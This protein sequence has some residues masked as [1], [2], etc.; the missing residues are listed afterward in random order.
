MTSRFLA[1]PIIRKLFRQMFRDRMR[2]NKKICLFL[3][4]TLGPSIKKIDTPITA[5]VDV[6]TIVV[7]TLARFAIGN[8]LSMIGDLYGIAESTASVIV[9]ECCKIIKYQLLPIV[10]E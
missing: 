5:S 3:C 1:Q 6:E 8:T 4:E 2:V 10:I 7:D 9:K